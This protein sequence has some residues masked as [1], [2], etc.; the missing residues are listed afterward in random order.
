VKSWFALAIA[1]SIVV[2][3]ARSAK[4]SVLPSAD[5]C[6]GD[7][8]LAEFVPGSPHAVSAAVDTSAA[9][10]ASVALGMPLIVLPLSVAHGAA[11]RH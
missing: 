10:Q 3:S 8:S 5:R 11:I 7:P 4:T 9:A 2:G 6:A 1:G